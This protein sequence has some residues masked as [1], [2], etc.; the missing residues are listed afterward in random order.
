MQRCEDCKNCIPCEVDAS[1]DEYNQNK[2]WELARCEKSIIA[3]TTKHNW[4][5]ATLPLKHQFCEIVRR[6]DTCKN[7]EVRS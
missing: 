2:K 5:S 4:V 6:E 3:E 7:Y 1:E